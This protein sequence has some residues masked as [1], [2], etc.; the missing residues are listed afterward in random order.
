M[1]FDEIKIPLFKKKKNVESASN[2]RLQIFALAIIF[3]LSAFL[4]W[5]FFDFSLGSQTPR[6]EIS[7]RIRSASESKKKQLLMEW[8]SHL[9]AVNQETNKSWLPN[10]AEHLDLI[11]LAHDEKAQFK[12]D[13]AS[14]SV[15]ALHVASWGDEFF[16]TKKIDELLESTQSSSS[17]LALGIYLARQRQKTLLR[18]NEKDFALQMAQDLDISVRKVAAKVLENCFDQNDC[19]GALS[20]LMSDPNDEIKW[21]AAL[22]VLRLGKAKIISESLKESAL[23]QLKSLS[24]RVFDPSKDNTFLSRFDEGAL[25]L[26]LNDL[27]RVL[28]V[29]EGENF[30]N[31]LQEIQ[32]SHP[33]LRLR[34]EARIFLKTL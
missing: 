31:Q 24:E 18:A 34:N 25:R 14:V 26:F 12:E 11:R 32:N 21:N 9:E 23:K 8:L 1:N 3:I 7:S 2:K 22:S 5:S 4:F 16:E 6:I 28:Q 27:F 33:N 15:I 17:K 10:S 29:Y 19:Q 13:N 30:K 20:T